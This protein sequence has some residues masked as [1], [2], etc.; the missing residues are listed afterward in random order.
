MK[1]S[2]Q[3]PNLSLKFILLLFAT[4][5]LS[6][7][8]VTGSVSLDGIGVS[9]ITVI[10]D[11]N[12]TR[13][14]TTTDANG[15]Y[16]FNDVSDGNYQVSIQ[17]PSTYSGK[18][19]ISITKQGDVNNVHFAMLSETIR[20]TAKGNVIGLAE[21]NHIHTWKGIPFAKPPVDNLRWKAPTPANA[22]GENPYLALKSKEGCVEPVGE[23]VPGQSATDATVKGS[24][25]CLYLD[26]QAPAFTAD[27]IPSGDDRLPVMVW[28]YGGGNV[29]LFKGGQN[30]KNLVKDHDMIVVTFNYRVGHMGWFSHPALANGNALDDSGNYGTLD[31][32]RVLNWV[33]DNIENFGGDPNNVTIGGLSAGSFNVYSLLLSPL[34]DGLF[35]KAIS[36][37]GYITTY[38]MET[39]QNYEEDGGYFNSS[40]EVMNNLLIQDGLAT[41][42]VSAKTLQNGMSNEEIED[43]LYSKTSAE[44]LT[45]G[46][47]PN[48][49][50]HNSTLKEPGYFSVVSKF[51][52]GVVLPTGDPLSLFQNNDT[53]NAVPLLVGATRDESKPFVAFDPEFVHLL[54]GL[55]IGSK[56]RNYYNL[57]NRYK[58][59]YFRI[60]G[61]DSV[62]QALAQ[63]PDQPD[64][65]TYQFDWDNSPTI[66]IADLPHLIGAAHALDAPFS[67]NI[68]DEDGDDFFST[69]F[70]TDQNGADRRG[71][72]ASMA[73][74]WAEFIHNGDP[75]MG[76][77]NSESTPWFA[78]TDT[79]DANNMMFLDGAEDA[80]IRMSH[81]LLTMEGLKQRLLT[82]TA[83]PSQQKHCHMY[84]E[85]FNRTIYWNNEEYLNLGENGCPPLS[86]P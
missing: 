30:G 36:Q 26:V 31:I 61:V 72:A 67:F 75:G 45:A 66:I 14:S 80:G 70:F 28:I 33:Q 82:E 60:K 63:N 48:R 11:G 50:P 34:A 57:F 78:W 74:Y 76:R 59:E 17:A 55:P 4:F 3:I 27:N 8:K 43:Y 41:D 69:Y 52:D 10:L 44:I 84:E 62:V 56:D 1:L 42:K 29:V 73:S 77:Q 51:R 49:Q 71:L 19:T 7:C 46:R 53:Y 6:A 5:V 40:R 18:A 64:L 58:G 25:D 15:N 9:G 85:L 39:V 20:T 65:F 2:F 12:S 35:H 23:L 13:R 68:T 37:S 38:E 79:P 47:G 16:S 81:S 24:E 83:F 21:D 54:A 86:S 32:I 22:W